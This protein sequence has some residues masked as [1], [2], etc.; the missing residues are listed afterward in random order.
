[1]NVLICK[2]IC[3]HDNLHACN[4]ARLLTQALFPFTLPPLLT[5]VSQVR[6]RGRGWQSDRYNSDASHT[7]FPN[8][9]KGDERQ[10]KRTKEDS[11]H[12]KIFG[13]QRIEVQRLPMWLQLAVPAQ[14]EKTTFSSLVKKVNVSAWTKRL[15]T[16]IRYEVFVDKV[17][18][19]FF[20]GLN[21]NQSKT[22]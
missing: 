16:R 8:E 19:L 22:K 7:W 14:P 17:Q 4:Q 2:Q 3:L 15:K 21:Q 9:C 13:A 11:D 10:P 18:H 20:T 12:G 6:D 5:Y 1:M